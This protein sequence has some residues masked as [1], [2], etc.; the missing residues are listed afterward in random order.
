MPAVK[1]TN[2]VLVKL[3]LRYQRNIEKQDS[4]YT[5][6]VLLNRAHFSPPPSS[7]LPPSSSLQ[8]PR[9]YLNQTIARNSAISPYL[10]Q[11]IKNCPFWLKIGTCGI[12]E[13]LIPNPG[14]DVWN[15][16]P[17]IQFWANS[18]QKVKV[19]RFN[20]KLAQIIY[21]GCWFLVQH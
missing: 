2:A 11:K 12:L 18:G 1:N 9:Q 14:L 13:V 3:L 6:R 21:W 8:R 20:W 16:D 7:F 10:G 15:F 4:S 5:Q 19:V 17:K